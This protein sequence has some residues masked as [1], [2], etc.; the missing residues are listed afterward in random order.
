MLFLF[1]HSRA[2]ACLKYSLSPHTTEQSRGS[3]VN[4][5]QVKIHAINPAGIYFFRVKNGNHV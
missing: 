2:N 4:F 3:I 1:E 5:E